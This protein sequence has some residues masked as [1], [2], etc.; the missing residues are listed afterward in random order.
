M[1]QQKSKVKY[2]KD[3]KE[4][5]YLISEVSLQFELGEEK[6]R[7]RSKLSIQKNKKVFSDS[8]KLTLN[9]EKLT[10]LSVELNGKMLSS[11]QYSVSDESLIISNPP[12]KFTL[13]I[14]NEIDPAN[15]HALEGLYK[16]GNIFC[17]Q[18]EPQ[19]FRKIT[20][21]LD[22]PDVM[23]KF[24]TTITA[25]KKKYPVLLSNGNPVKKGSQPNGKHFV[26]W[27]D[28]F[29]KP[30]YLFALVAGDLGLVK[31]VHKAKS[32]RTINLRIYVDKGNEDRCEYAMGA[33]KRAMKW[34]EDAFGL[35]CDLSTYM[36]V[37][38]DTFNMGAMENKGLNIFNSQYILAN[39]KTA[40][41]Q[42]YEAIEG[43]IGHEYFHNWT[44]NRVTC[45]DWFQITLKEG[46]TVYRDQEFSC[47]MSSRA[48]KRISNVRVLRDH[49]FVEDAGPNAHP[50]QP[51]SY[52]EI[53]NFYTVTVYEK[54]AEVIRMIETLIGKETFREGITKYFELFDG[55]AVTTDD[56]V[57]AMEQASRKNLTQFKNWYRQAGTPICKVD[58]KFNR[59]KQ[60]VELTIEQKNSS[61]SKARQAR[62]FYFP[63]SVG[64]LDDQ[65][66][67]LIGT[68]VLTISKPV[69]TFTF[70]D[71]SKKPVPSL[72]RN[73][74]APVK[75]EYD[76]SLHDLIHLLMCDSDS[77][78]RYE[79]AQRLATH[80][81]N[82]VMA[83]QKQNKTPTIDAQ[84][85]HAFGVLLE[86]SSIDP[87]F[88]TECLV[89]PSVT[90]LTEQMTV[91]DFENAFQ[92]RQFF[93][94]LLASQY[95]NV[96]RKFYDELHDSGPHQ[97]DG[98]SV[99]KRTFKNLCLS[100]LA[101]LEKRD[102]FQLVFQQFDH[103]TNMTDEI[104]GLGILC[105]YEIPQRKNAVAAF[106]KKWR[107]DTLVM[108]KWFAAQASSKTP[109][110]LKQV[111]ALTKNPAYDPRNPNKIRSLIGVFAHN[112][113]RFHDASGMGY[114]FVADQ[115]LAVDQFNPIVSS[116]LSEAFKKYPRLDEGRK[117][118]MGRELERILETK[119]L[120]RDVYEIV[121][122]TLGKTRAGVN[123]RV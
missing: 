28:P 76:Y 112:L 77:F 115:L 114:Q 24:T 80:A 79:A 86:D 15:N 109:D 17:T 51:S 3:Y 102:Y 92:A 35:E 7:V 85:V 119:A 66:R 39:P 122:K 98:A 72:L 62:P 33:L 32:G 101:S 4:P 34:D 87:L 82:Q 73:F 42:N 67:D 106:Y 21:Y 120:S 123:V 97:V 71:I 88:K 54:G 55:H 93:V 19:G 59:P 105:D 83:L 53:N 16:S 57:F 37:A 8:K 56:F 61:V 100:Y 60:R 36:I 68:R 99:G 84:I 113:V 70:D 116:R 12:Q 96:F 41:D 108:N 9:G 46:L 2:L 91:C 23:A 103:A 48:V 110:V 14:E 22:R 45:R 11:K 31:G 117:A 63:F 111:K 49:Q 95:E 47:D 65:G 78:N 81:L 43:V 58:L 1:N 107:K 74:S 40:T 26:T 30:S 38:V 44:G 104:Q 64:F 29:P 118:L 10:L 20:Y 90:A 5:D 27:E 121:S 75:L 6:T 52:L 18:N 69:E 25:D 50:I 13:E 89:L 94:K